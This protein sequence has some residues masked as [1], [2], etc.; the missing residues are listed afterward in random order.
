MVEVEG[1]GMVDVEEDDME[2]ASKLE[3]LMEEDSAI[4]INKI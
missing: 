3:E 2:E 1:D 4:R